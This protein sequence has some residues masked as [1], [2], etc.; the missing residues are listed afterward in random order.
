MEKGL[1]DLRVFAAG[2]EA[3]LLVKHFSKGHSRVNFNEF[4]GMLVSRENEF[5]RLIN[6][7]PREGRRAFSLAT[8]A[9]L[10]DLLRLH[11]RAVSMAESF[12]Q[13][14]ARQPGFTMSK[15]FSD[16]DL[17][18]SGYITQNEFESM[19]QH[20]GFPVTQ[21]DLQSLME[22]YDKNGDG[23]V[24]YGEFVQETTPQ[25]PKKY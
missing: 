25:S 16:L 19:L 17:D 6:S 11:L 1:N 10:Q 2:D 14:L 5:A 22:R 12:R 9:K 23:R 3:S 13:R 15:A 7:R 20:H 18:K 21:A 8:E 24:S 4:C